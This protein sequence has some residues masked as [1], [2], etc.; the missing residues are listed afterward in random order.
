MDIV[1]FNSK[2]S[3]LCSN[4]SR[5]NYLYKVPF[6]YPRMS[7]S[8]IKQ[9]NSRATAHVVLCTPRQSTNS[10]NQ[11]CPFYRHIKFFNVIL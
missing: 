8:M 4:R 11:T 7:R 1:G 10:S 5:M 2:P 6:V 3:I 9:Q